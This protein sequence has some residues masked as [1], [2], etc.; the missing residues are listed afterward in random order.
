MGAAMVD[1]DDL[2]DEID[3]YDFVPRTVSAFAKLLMEKENMQAWNDFI[4]AS[5]E[6]QEFFLGSVDSD[7]ED[8]GVNWGP[9]GGKAG[10]RRRRRAY[11]SVGD[12]GDMSHE[13]GMLSSS[14][15]DDDDEKRDRHP[16]YSADLSFERIDAR[17]KNI[18]RRQRQLPM[19]SN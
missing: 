14:L 12:T 4:S 19:V 5:E 8:G 9:N 1:L 18:L 2:T 3:I 15:T 17:L 6:D 10:H 16:A 13:H 7:E 11:H